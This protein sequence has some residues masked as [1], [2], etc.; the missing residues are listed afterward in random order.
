MSRRS[1]RSGERSSPPAGGPRPRVWRPAWRSSS[2]PALLQAIEAVGLSPFDAAE[3]LPRN[4]VP[5]FNRYSHSL[6]PSPLAK[7]R[8]KGA[9][10]SW[11]DNLAREV[12]R[13]RAPKK[14][15]FCVSRKQRKQVLF[16][17][18]IAGRRGVGRG[19]RWLRSSTSS[20][21]C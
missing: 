19:K 3:D 10:G 6:I 11:Q 17:K 4:Y 12:M 9:F 1:R 8:P 15:M 13:V 20:Y 18:G 21:R 5:K 2:A 16:A 14:V 7:Q